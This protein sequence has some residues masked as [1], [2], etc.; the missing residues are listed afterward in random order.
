MKSYLKTFCLLVCRILSKSVF[1]LPKWSSSSSKWTCSGNAQFNIYFYPFPMLCNIVSLWSMSAK[2]LKISALSKMHLGRAACFLNTL[3]SFCLVLLCIPKKWH[4][5]WNLGL[6]VCLLAKAALN[7][8]FNYQ[9]LIIK[10]GLTWASPFTKKTRSDGLI[11]EQYS[12]LTCWRPM[13]IWF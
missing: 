2:A 1:L 13:L 9:R 12:S 7:H 3:K 4:A 6:P 11:D 5:Q 10:S 8:T